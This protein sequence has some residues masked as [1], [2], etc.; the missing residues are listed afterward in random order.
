[1]KVYAFE[2][3][4]CSFECEFRIISLHKTK[5]GAYRA[6]RQHRF[7]NWVL[8]LE[9]DQRQRRSSVHDYEHYEAFCQWQIKEYVV[10]D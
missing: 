10:E 2:Y 1:M 6:M 8:C 7:D 5:A 9:M 3:T 4:S